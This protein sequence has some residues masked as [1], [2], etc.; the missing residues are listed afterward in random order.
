MQLQ[1]QRGH[2]GVVF[3]DTRTRTIHCQLS[4]RRQQRINDLVQR[5]L[6]NGT[7]THTH[8]HTQGERER[9]R[10]RHT[11]THT[12]THTGGEREREREM[13]PVHFQWQLNVWGLI[14]VRVKIMHLNNDWSWVGFHRSASVTVMVEPISRSSSSGRERGLQLG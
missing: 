6:I 1:H 3:R 5:R 12:H 7:H 2:V 8:T 10:E 4:L 14:R 9:E 13:A 11:H